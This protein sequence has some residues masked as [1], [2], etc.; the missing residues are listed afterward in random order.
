[1]VPNNALQSLHFPLPSF[2]CG[3]TRCALFIGFCGLAGCFC[4]WLFGGRAYVWPYNGLFKG[5]WL[6]WAFL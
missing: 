2:V 6:Y 3:R 5:D 4:P 1:M